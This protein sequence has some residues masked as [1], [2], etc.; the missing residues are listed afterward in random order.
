MAP[1]DD[2]AKEAGPFQR[3]Q[4]QSSAKQ[5]HKAFVVQIPEGSIRSDHNNAISTHVFRRRAN[6]SGFSLKIVLSP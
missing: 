6:L 1:T 4:N 5:P 3:N 2:G